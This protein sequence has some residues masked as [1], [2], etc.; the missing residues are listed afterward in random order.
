MATSQSSGVGMVMCPLCDD[1]S[2]SPSSVEAHISRLTDPDHQGEVGRAHRDE[3]QSGPVVDGLGEDQQESTESSSSESVEVEPVRPATEVVEEAGDEEESTEEAETA[4]S[5]G[6]PI[7]VSSTQLFA[8]VAILMVAVFVWSRFR[9]GNEQER[10]D[11]N[12][13]QPTTAGGRMGGY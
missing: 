9:A 1:Y 2:G 3:L 7:P 12:Q 13:Q 4:G 10:E 11:Q 6:I 5:A 8:G